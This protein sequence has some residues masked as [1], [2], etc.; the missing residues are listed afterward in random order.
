MELPGTKDI[1][2]FV[3]LIGEDALSRLPDLPYMV[4]ETLA[5]GNTI[6]N[7]KLNDKYQNEVG[8]VWKRVQSHPIYIWLDSKDDF[9][10]A[11][12]TYKKKKAWAADNDLIQRIRFVRIIGFNLCLYFLKKKA[13]WA[14]LAPYKNQ[15]TK[16]LGY[17]RKLSAELSAGAIG[18]DN[19]DDS[20]QLKKLLRKLDEELVA[21][22]RKPRRDETWLEREL[23]SNIAL[24]LLKTFGDASP[25]ILTDIAALIGYTYEQKVLDPALRTAR[26]EYEK[27]KLEEPKTRALTFRKLPP[28]KISKN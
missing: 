5:P 20:E 12:N 22:K 26:R 25:A 6:I 18:L 2:S 4:L 21:A 8:A 15:I 23:I 14:P 1:E 10:N 28:T 11:F 24:Q 13:E 17:T 16:V 27:Q 3:K 7:E 19:P 9:R